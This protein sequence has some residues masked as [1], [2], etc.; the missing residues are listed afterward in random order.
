MWTG[1]EQFHKWWWTRPAGARALIQCRRSEK[2]RPVDAGTPA[3]ADEDWTQRSDSRVAEDGDRDLH[4]E[5]FTSL[6]VDT[7]DHAHTSPRCV[8]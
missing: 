4:A 8:S 7:G 3:A 1:L 2:T 6:C 5:A